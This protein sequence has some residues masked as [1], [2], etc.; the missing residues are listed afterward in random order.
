MRFLLAI[1]VSVIIVG[2]S[3][4]TQSADESSGIVRKQ[5][6][7]E[8]AMS[9]GA[10]NALAY[11]GTRY[12]VIL[13]K[14]ANQLDNIFNFRPFILKNNVLPP[15]VRQARN[16]LKVDDPNTLRL[17]DRIIEILTPA[18]FVTT[19]PTWRDYLVMPIRRANLPMQ[20]L[21]PTSRDEY[22]TWVQNVTIGWAQGRKQAYDVINKRLAFLKRDYTGMSLYY[23]LLVQNMISEPQVGRSNLGITGNSKKVRLNDQLMRITANSDLKPRGANHWEPVVVSEMEVPKHASVPTGESSK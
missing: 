21:R 12:N 6:I 15:V 2:C 18:K 13:E 20:R 3:S 9:F 4:S 8:E 11:Y 14:N 7:T 22:N 19:A 10:Q 23:Q 1:L 16:D 5:I 17:S